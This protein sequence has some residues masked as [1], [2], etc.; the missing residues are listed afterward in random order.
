MNPEVEQITLEVPN[1]VC[2][3]D[4]HKCCNPV[5]ITAREAKRLGIEGEYW[6]GK[7]GDGKCRFLG[8]KGCTKYRRRPLA[9][10]LFGS[11]ETGLFFCPHLPKQKIP[12]LDL[13]Q[14]VQAAQGLY[15]ELHICGHFDKFI[16]DREKREHCR[17]M[18]LQS[19]FK[20]SSE[21]EADGP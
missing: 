20:P 4:C 7:R 9:C 12:L 13:Q 15:T 5:A 19:G 8:P 21:A 16:N 11:S 3:K 6:T 17:K 1:I 10:I 2:P 14:M 18:D